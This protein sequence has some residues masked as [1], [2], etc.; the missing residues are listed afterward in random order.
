MAYDVELAD[1]IRVVGHRLCVRGRTVGQS[2]HRVDIVEVR[3][4]AGG[5]PYLVRYA[6]GHEAVV[7]PGPD[8]VVEPAADSAGFGEADGRMSEET[9]VR[10][11]EG[12]P[13]SVEPEVDDGPGVRS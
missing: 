6:D 12:P 1:R 13:T 3:G 11:G 2:D 5:P 10:L 8:A 4:A 7:F 9:G